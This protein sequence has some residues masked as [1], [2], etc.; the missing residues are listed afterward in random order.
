MA[1]PVSER[2]S[3]RL[4]TIGSWEAENVSVGQVEAAL[5]DL[6][7]EVSGTENYDMRQDLKKDE[8]VLKSIISRLGS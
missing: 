1:P 8:D 3:A 2:D 5:S 4:T 7:M 6:R